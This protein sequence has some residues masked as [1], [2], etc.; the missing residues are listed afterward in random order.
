MLQRSV[1]AIP[2]EVMQPRQ[3]TGMLGSACTMAGIHGGVPLVWEADSVIAI[4]STAGLPKYMSNN[5]KV[6]RI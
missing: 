3:Q 4:P 6:H 5:I 2:V 1:K